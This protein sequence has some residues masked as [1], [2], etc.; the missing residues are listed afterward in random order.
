M[1]PADDIKRMIKKL[2]DT[3]S[4]EMDRKVLRDSLQVLADSKETQSADTRPN[5]WRIIMIFFQ[6]CV[7]YKFYNLI[8]FIG[9]TG[10]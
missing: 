6:I 10:L 1:R 5:K 7:N 3:T 4:A 8:W 2:N 9:W